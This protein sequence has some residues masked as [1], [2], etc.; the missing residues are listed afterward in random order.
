MTQ[1][2]Q[3]IFTPLLLH[4]EEL[5]GDEQT[6]QELKK[7]TKIWMEISTE[8]QLAAKTPDETEKHLAYRIVNSISH[9]RSRRKG[10]FTSTFTVA[11]SYDKELL[12]RGF[13]FI[14]PIDLPVQIS[15]AAP[16]E[17]KK[18]FIHLNYLSTDPENPSQTPP[19]KGVGTSLIL[20][21]FEKCVKEN[22][23]GI[24]AEPLPQAQSFL[25]KH[26]FVTSDATGSQKFAMVWETPTQ[27]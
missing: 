22:Y 10:N 11:I 5:P 3:K 26:G 15:E 23:D 27:E 24:F 12:I 20:F 18:R 21:L 17:S 19:V 9:Q 7:V 2:A 1:I 13:A 8:R 16:S 25:S 6:R 14:K 4:V